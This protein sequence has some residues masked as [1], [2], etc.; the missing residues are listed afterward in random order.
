MVAH[1]VAKR[2]LE[3]ALSSLRDNKEEYQMVAEHFRKEVLKVE[4]FFRSLKL[5]IIQEQPEYDVRSTYEIVS[6][7]IFYPN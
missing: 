3:D 5:Q 6:W 4:V 1:A 7:K 2:G